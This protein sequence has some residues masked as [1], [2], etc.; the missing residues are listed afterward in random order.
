MKKKGE[1]GRSY[2]DESEGRTDKSEMAVTGASGLDKPRGN[3]AA[4]L[5]ALTASRNG[6]IRKRQ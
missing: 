1:G 5:L 6:L 4:A 2:D 3:F